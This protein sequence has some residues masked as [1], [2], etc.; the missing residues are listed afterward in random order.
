[1][2][3]SNRLKQTYHRVA[4]RIV[5]SILRSGATYVPGN[6]DL[7][8]RHGYHILPV[9]FYPPVPDTRI[10]ESSDLWTRPRDLAGIDWNVQRQLDHLVNILPAWGGEFMNEL[11][12]GQ[13]GRFGFCLDNDA[14]AGLDPFVLYGFIRH[15]QPAMVLEIGSGHSTRVMAAALSRN[16]Q[17]FLIS[18]DPYPGDQLRSDMHG[19]PHAF[20]TQKAE[21]LQYDL[22]DRLD[23][24]D[25]L[26]IDSTH[27]VRCGGDVNFLL[28]EVLPRLRPG[29]I[30]HLHDIFLPEEYPREWLLEKHIFWAEQ[31]L[32]HAF[33]IFNS[34]YEILM[35]NNFVGKMYPDLAKKH[36]P[37]ALWWGGGSFWMRRK[38][39]DVGNQP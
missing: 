26:F 33:L 7:W 2:P 18:A 6:F 21:Q 3:M 23:S 14:Y 15:Y 4:A 10:L 22:F 24:G 25:V 31:Y 38:R 36:F 9:H 32:L 19:F 1:M 35:A 11:V 29:V 34:F 30:V 27:T 13:L 20:I 39:F 17:G 28:L 16:E 8:Q 5:T 37:Q 12:D